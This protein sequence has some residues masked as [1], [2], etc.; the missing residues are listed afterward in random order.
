[1][2]QATC[3]ITFHVNIAQFNQKQASFFHEVLL[4]NRKLMSEYRIDSNIIPCSSLAKTWLLFFDVA[5]Y[6]SKTALNYK[7]QTNYAIILNG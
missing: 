5:L 4:K 6:A 1:V 2:S 3:F 7:N